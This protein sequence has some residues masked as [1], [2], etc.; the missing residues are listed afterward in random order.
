METVLVKAKPEQPLK[1]IQQGKGKIYIGSRAL[2]KHG[3]SCTAIKKSNK[4]VMIYILIPKAI[5]ITR[6][7][8]DSQ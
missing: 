8:F 6:Y 1:V 5:K 4:W 3:E 2:N 7:N